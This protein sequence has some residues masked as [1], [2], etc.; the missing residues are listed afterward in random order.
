MVDDTG[1]VVNYSDYHPFGEISTSWRAYNE[2]MKFSGKEQDDY[3]AFDYHYF[4]ARYYDPKIGNFS[5]IDKAAQ[6]SNGF[7]YCDNNP[8]SLSDPDGNLIMDIVFGVM[9]YKHYN[10]MLD[11][12]DGDHLSAALLTFKEGFTSWGMSKTGAKM[13]EAKHLRLLSGSVLQTGQSGRPT[14]YYGLGSYDILSGKNYQTI[15]KWEDIFSSYSNFSGILD[16]NCD[17]ATIMGRI[18]SKIWGNEVKVNGL[19]GNQLYQRT[20]PG[21]P[22]GTQFIEKSGYFHNIES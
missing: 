5:S 11:K 9:L 19:S 8:I 15:K 14:L 17:Y 1:T 3:G 6:L 4:G 10:N 12:Y 16:F 21:K 20:K 2:P 13:A 7:L 22:L 18:E